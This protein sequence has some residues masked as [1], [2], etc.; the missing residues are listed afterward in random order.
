MLAA[1]DVALADGAPATDPRVILIN[2]GESQ[3]ARRVAPNGHALLRGGESGERYV[4]GG[5]DMG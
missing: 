4:R 3:T 2:L 1:S 5:G